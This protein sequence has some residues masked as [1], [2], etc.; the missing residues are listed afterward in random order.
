MKT[1]KTL[2]SRYLAPT[3]VVILTL[4]SGM[5]YVWSEYKGTLKE[6]ESLNAQKAEL[7]KREYVLQQR[8]AALQQRTGEYEAAFG[9]LQQS[10]SSVS[11]AQRQKE[12]EDKL[13]TLMSQF[14]EMGIN[15]NDQLRCGD[16]DGR[17]RYNAARAKYWEIYALAE[18]NGM[19]EKF[20]SFFFHNGHHVAHY[21]CL[22]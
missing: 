20:K 6:R 5:G 17:T 18:A 13:Q 22:E 15:L 2:S 3:A 9:K 12:A 16:T 14:S 10:Q 4:A 21:S 1:A 8:E 7:D 11:H 19:T